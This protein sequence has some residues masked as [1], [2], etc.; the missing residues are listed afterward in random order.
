MADAVTRVEDAASLQNAIDKSVEFG[1]IPAG[2]EG[3]ASD[4]V[5]VSIIEE[6]KKQVEGQ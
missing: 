1:I 3:P 6:A 2:I 4:Y 5:D